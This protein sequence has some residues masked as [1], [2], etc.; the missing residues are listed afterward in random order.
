MGLSMQTVKTRSQSQTT[1]ERAT[2]FA[3]VRG[4]TLQR[5]CACGGAPGP[6]GECEACR[7][8]RESKTLERAV[9]HPL[10]PGVHRSE[11]PP[12]VHEVLRAPGQ[13]LDAETRASME[14]R[15]GHDFSHVRVHT[16]AK[17]AESARAVNAQAYTVGR[18]L[19]FGTGEY[20]PQ[21]HSGR[22]VLG[23]ELAHVVQQKAAD[24]GASGPFGVG[25]I[26]D[27]Y[28]Q[29]AAAAAEGVVADRANAAH[30]A[31][32]QLMPAS[33]NILRR[34][35]GKDAA[36]S[37]KG[38]VG[39][40]QIENPT[41]EKK[42]TTTTVLNRFLQISSGQR[43]INDVWNLFCRGKRR[44]QA[45]VTIHMVDA[46]PPE[47]GGGA[48]GSFFPPEK[49]EPHYDVYVLYRA[50]LTEDERRTKTHIGQWP[51][52]KSDLQIFY[53]AEESESNMATTLFHELLHVW[54]IN[55]GVYS[56]YKTGHWDVEKGEFEVVYFER[57][58]EA[59][60]EIDE[61][62]AKINNEVDANKVKAPSANILPGDVP[63]PTNLPRHL[64]APTSKP[65][66]LG[67]E[68]SLQAGGFRGQGTLGKTAFTS[69]VGADVVLGRI[70]SLHLGARGLYLTPNHLLAGGAIGVRFRE[71][72]QTEIGSR[73]VENPLFF[74]IEAGVLAEI[75][76]KDA[77][78]VTNKIL[79]MASIS[80]GQEYGHEGARFFW[81]VQ[82]F[83]VVSDRKET[84][85]GLTAGVGV[86]F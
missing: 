50:P 12:I 54:F 43:L 18:D 21:T 5:K 22:R 76:A 32:Q 85:G 35:P 86:E 3:P 57:L 42:A 29:Q 11:V 16:D 44:C 83:A 31:S 25:P 1:T 55:Q 19:V 67:A 58:K 66:I 51:Q 71:G 52:G 24:A 72:D 17:A 69:L 60:K 75:P 7:K 4:G 63:E 49:D 15:F 10:S 6:S 74:D 81:K 34:V 80:V 2:S 13:P 39:Q 53:T 14:P 78:R 41:A 26:D 28:E 65:S 9:A 82:G 33:P 46:L 27:A 59:Y 77:E 30:P 64:G 37:W 84:A 47:I 61:L 48:D 79:G 36:D 56:A 20:Q 73:T 68:L 40:V 62:E 23:H 45:D 38:I 70:N 8:K